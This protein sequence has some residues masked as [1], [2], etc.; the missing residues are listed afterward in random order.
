MAK[1]LVPK[2]QGPFK[3]IKSYAGSP[4]VMNEKKGKNKIRIPC[5]SWEHAEE[6]CRRLN[7]ED[8]DGTIHA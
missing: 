5:K 1:Y 3:V 7:E 6:I 2:G 4:L 8:H